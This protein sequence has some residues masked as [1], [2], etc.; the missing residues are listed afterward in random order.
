MKNFFYIESPGF[1]YCAGLA[2]NLLTLFILF[3]IDVTYNNI[4]VPEVRYEENIWKAADVL[5]YVNLARNY[6]EFGVVGEEY[7]PTSERTIGY[8]V[9]ISVFINLF[10]ENWLFYFYLMQAVIFAFVYPAVTKIIEIIFPG[11]KKLI[12][13]VFLFLLFTGV[14]FT[15]TTV[16]MTDTIFT[17][18]LISGAAFGFYAVVKKNYFLLLLQLL[19][20]GIASQFRPI[21][22]LYV[23]PNILILTAVSVKYEILKEKKVKKIILISSVFLLLLTNI[24]SLRNYINYNVFSPSTVIEDNLL[25]SHATKI[26]ME[27][28]E[29]ETIED[30][31]SQ[32]DTTEN[33]A[34]MQETKIDYSISTYL[35][36]PVLASILFIKNVSKTL[37]RNH[38]SDFAHFWGYD[39]KDKIREVQTSLKKSEFVFMLTL[40]L[41]LIYLIIYFF[42]LLFIIKLL[43]EKK[44]LYLFSIMIFTGYF[45]IPGGFVSEEVRFRQP[46]ES[47]IVLF[48]FYEIQRIF[49]GKFSFR[50]KTV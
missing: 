37:I 18:F 10:G 15:Y 7:L 44:Y 20:I 48:S 22:F 31:Y 41:G 29:S 23:I 9:L 17:V 12:S 38:Y 39:F 35:E 24:P 13:A 49:S 1:Q 25:R 4:Q 43:K 47:F 36:Y 26:L 40:L 21:L 33:L 5:G 2:V 42:F 45:L 16:I 3:N 14:Y 27:K 32:I 46:V 34:K 50:R 11:N 8:P 6:I 28:E 19:I 30:I